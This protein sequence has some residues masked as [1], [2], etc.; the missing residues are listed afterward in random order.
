MVYMYIPS[1]RDISFIF[2]RLLLTVYGWYGGYGPRYNNGKEGSE[3]TSVVYIT[4][5]GLDD[6][7]L[8]SVSSYLRESA[9]VEVVIGDVPVTTPTADA[10]QPTGNNTALVGIVGGVVVA[11]LVLVLLIVI[12]TVYGRKRNPR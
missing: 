7:A 2:H 3:E 6:N 9:G 5:E 10:T 1:S 8:S 4:Y 11:I 12:I